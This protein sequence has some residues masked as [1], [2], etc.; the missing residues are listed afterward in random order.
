MVSISSTVAVNGQVVPGVEASMITAIEANGA[1]VT[2]ALTAA[3][4]DITASPVGSD[5]YNAALVS[6]ALSLPSPNGIGLT[7]AQLGGKPS[8]G[9]TT[10]L[11]GIFT[12]SQ[13][14]P[15]DYFTDPAVFLKTF[16]GNGCPDAATYNF[17]A[18]STS[19]L[20][21]PLLMTLGPTRGTRRP[22]VA[23]HL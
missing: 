14:L 9:Y 22:T 12:A 19:R 21:G 20:T 16:A 13:G 4:T 15:S 7:T 11:T 3:G 17:L 1:Y 6:F 5:A 18:S 8:A 2:G 23:R 10:A